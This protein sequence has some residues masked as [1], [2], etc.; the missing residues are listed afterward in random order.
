[1]KKAEAIP[2]ALFWD[3]DASRLDLQEN[4][5]YIIERILELGDEKAVSWLFSNYS[6]S[7]IKEGLRKSR[8]ISRKSRNYWILVLEK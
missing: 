1:M 5:Q 3:V 4:K 7:D 8:N 6:R 2:Q